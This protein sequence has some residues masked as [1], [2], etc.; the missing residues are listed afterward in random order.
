MSFVSRYTGEEISEHQ[1]IFQSIEMILTTRI[2]TRVMRRDFGSRLMDL[3]D[4]NLDA[5]GITAIYAATNEAIAI[6]EPRVEVL[7]TR[8]D[9]EGFKRGVV[10]L[11]ITLLVDGEVVEQDF[12][13]PLNPSTSTPTGDPQ[14]PLDPST[15][16]GDP[17]T[18]LDPST[19]T[20][21]GFNTFLFGSD[22]TFIFGNNIFGWE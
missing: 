13:F 11:I 4:A 16:T 9:P 6:W 12:F 22:Q 19:P 18:P 10:I 5:N 15:P 21:S 7:R 20:S 1:H 14:T 17:S 2:G 8:M 3:I